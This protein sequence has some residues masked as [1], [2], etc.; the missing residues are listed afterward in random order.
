[1]NVEKWEELN[2]VIKKFGIR[3]F[4]T[5]AV[6][7]GYELDFP[8]EDGNVFWKAGDV[9]ISM[10]KENFDKL[11]EHEQAIARNIL[12]TSMFLASGGQTRT[13]R[14]KEFYEMYYGQTIKDEK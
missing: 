12:E 7:P 1:M 11:T 8:D 14:S 9:D 6:A 10:A 2:E 4:Q 13:P 3:N 5:R